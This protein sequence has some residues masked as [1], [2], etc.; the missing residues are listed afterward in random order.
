MRGIANSIYMLR[1]HME[2]YASCVMLFF[3]LVYNSVWIG[4][5]CSRI[6]S[7]CMNV[8]WVIDSFLV[9][10]VRWKCTA[11]RELQYNVDEVFHTAQE[12]LIKAHC[13]YFYPARLP[14]MCY[15][16]PSHMLGICGIDV[17][18]DLFDCAASLTIY[19]CCG[20]TWN[21]MH[22]VLFKCEFWYTI[23][24]ECVYCVSVY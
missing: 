8:L 13:P 7:N 6:L 19:N 17:R 10:T 9:Y 20:I 12:A 4:T 14:N 23:R 11:Q 3:V 21:V 22:H 16:R 15:P 24:L 5:Q 18:R 2:F 1:Y